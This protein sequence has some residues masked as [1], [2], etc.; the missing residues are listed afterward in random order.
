[1]IYALDEVV[2]IST[3][4]GTAGTTLSGIVTCTT[5]K[6]H[7]LIVGN[8]IKITGVTGADAANF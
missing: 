7:G 6:S 2:P 8:K 3:I 5:S 1:M 4:V